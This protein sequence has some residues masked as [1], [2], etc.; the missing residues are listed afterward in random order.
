MIENGL[1]FAHAP[2]VHVSTF[3]G[4]DHHEIDAFEVDGDV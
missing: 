3:G 2:F 4:P 1:D